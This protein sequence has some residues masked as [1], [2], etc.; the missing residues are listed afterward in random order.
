MRKGHEEKERS[1]RGIY[2]W[3]WGS[4]WAEHESRGFH[5]A[6]NTKTRMRRK[7]PT[8]PNSKWRRVS[9]GGKKLKQRKM[10]RG[11][12]KEIGRVGRDR[13]DQGPLGSKRF[14]ARAARKYSDS[15]E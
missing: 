5:E 9:Q 1:I 11:G 3:V 12:R 4:C 7:K 6:S 8:V 14:A 2:L 15:Q 13:K 10:K